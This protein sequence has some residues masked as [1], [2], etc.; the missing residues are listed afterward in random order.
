VAYQENALF[1]AATVPMRLLTTAVFF[2]QGWAVPAVWGGVGAVMA[3]I[4]LLNT[5]RTS[6]RG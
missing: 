4:A 5:G 3:A 6:K 2:T 1:F